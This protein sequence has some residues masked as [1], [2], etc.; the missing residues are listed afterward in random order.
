MSQTSSFVTLPERLLAFATEATQGTEFF[1]LDVK[2]RAAKG[3]TVLEVVADT[4]AGIGIDDLTRL[5]RDLRFLF[6]THEVISG[7]Y[8]LNV[9]SPGLRE[10][11]IPRQYPRHV[12][13][14]LDVHIKPKGEETAP[15]RVEGVLTAA[16]EEG[17]TLELTGSTSRS[18]PFTEIQ[19]ARVKL[20]W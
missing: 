18:I 7:E 19:R 6:D 2:V 17:I 13:R 15:E 5:S 3:E 16:D 4:D 9:L 10:P 20:P 12:G 8:S 11:L 1:V 14:S